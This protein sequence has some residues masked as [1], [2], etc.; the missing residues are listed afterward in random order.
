MHFGVGWL[1]VLSAKK[2]GI[3][4]SFVTFKFSTFIFTMRTGHIK[5]IPVNDSSTPPSF[6]FSLYLFPPC[7]CRCRLGGKSKEK[8]ERRKMADLFQFAF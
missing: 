1:F 8:E 7:A 2:P 6:F 3:G 5:T 4:L